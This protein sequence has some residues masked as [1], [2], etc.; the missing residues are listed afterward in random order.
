MCTSALE[1]ARPVSALHLDQRH[2]L[3]RLDQPQ[4]LARSQPVRRRRE[5]DPVRPRRER[6]LAAP[7]ADR[8][9]RASR[10]RP[11]PRPRHRCDSAPSPR[12]PV[13]A[14]VV[15]LDQ[16]RERRLVAGRRSQRQRVVGSI[17]A[18]RRRQTL[19]PRSQCLLAL[20]A[21]PRGLYCPLDAA[22]AEIL[23]SSD[24]CELRNGSLGRGAENSSGLWPQANTA[25]RG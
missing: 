2:H 12:Q 24:A 20:V 19:D 18:L 4:P 6:R 1:L 14:V 10:T 9:G 15:P 23:G 21:R 16:R 22:I 3:R 7:A 11:A 13:E 8:A 17:A 5:H 25:T